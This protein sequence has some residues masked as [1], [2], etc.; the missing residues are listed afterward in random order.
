MTVNETTSNIGGG[1][2]VASVTRFYLSVN[3]AIDTGDVELGTR[4][5][6][7]LAAGATSSGQTALVIPANT[8]PG[9]YWIIAVS[10]S[11]GTVV[12]TFETNNNRIAFTRVTIGG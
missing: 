3:L 4:N 8:A 1:S 5:V 9:T 6:P 11:T 2:A 12:E 10:D 7:T